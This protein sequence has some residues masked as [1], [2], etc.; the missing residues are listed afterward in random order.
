MSHSAG[1]KTAIQTYFSFTNAALGAVAEQV[2]RLGLKQ[3]EC[4]CSRI[5]GLRAIV[6][7][8]GRIVLYSRY[9]YGNR[10]WRIKLGELGLITLDQ[11]RKEH[12]SIRARAARGE[13]PKAPTVARLL[14]REL[15]EQHYIVQCQS[16]GKK[17]LATDLSRYAHW[18]G[19]EFGDKRVAD[20]TKTQVS[21]FAIKMQEAGLAASTTRSTI[22]QLGATLEI[23]IDLDVLSR[24]PAR[25]LRL[26]KAQTRRAEHLTVAQMSAFIAAARASNNIV[27]SYMLIIMALTG[28]RLGEARAARWEHIRLDEGVWHLPTQ[29]SGEPTDLYLSDLVKRFFR[30]LEPT[31]R[32]A[33]VFPGARGN[34]QLARPIAL[35][36]RLCEQAGIPPTFR[37]HDLRHAWVSAGVN[38]GI[39]LE[40]MSQG[41]RHSSPVVTRIYSHV[42][43]EVLR[44]AQARIAGLFLGG[45][46]GAQAPAARPA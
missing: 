26:P 15:H 13:N 5:P 7:A 1:R 6:Y 37:I 39:P 21:R 3:V 18:I 14:F 43:R 11:A 40:I 30:E 4:S 24:N 35:F 38:V 29:K 45:A 9:S 36:K 12:Q 22:S 8:S 31:R 2:R 10:P 28:T 25:G 17:T 41:A 32:N 46:A 33:F 27:G 19:P 23:A 16:R 42:E 34:A 44:S 20:I